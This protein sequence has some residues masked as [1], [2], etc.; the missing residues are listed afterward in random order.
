MSAYAGLV[1]RISAL[2]IDGVLMTIAVPAVALGPP[3]MWASLEGAAPG[4]LKTACA[5]AAGLVP[6]FY[7]AVCWWGTGQ[8]FGGLVLGTIVRRSDGTHLGVIRATLRAIVGLA[9]PIV[10]LLGMVTAL[11]D[12]RRR[13]LHDRIFGTVVRY[14]RPG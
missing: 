5:F 1:T 14:K 13:A 3:A 12:P 11:W 2:A 4:W 9:L 7:F 8:T 6:V 10:W